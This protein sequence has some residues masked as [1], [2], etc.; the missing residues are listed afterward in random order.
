MTLIR[1]S[2]DS[3]NSFFP[4]S[5]IGQASFQVSMPMW[6]QLKELNTA[7][8]TDGIVPLSS[9][10]FHQYPVKLSGAPPTEFLTDLELNDT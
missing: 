3:L 10:S 7:L 9:P 4:P 6:G 1:F 2:I 5:V 8:N